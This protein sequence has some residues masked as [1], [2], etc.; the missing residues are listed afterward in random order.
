MITLEIWQVNE[1]KT[2]YLLLTLILLGIP[3]TGISQ[4]TDPDYLYLAED[5]ITLHAG[6]S[7]GKQIQLNDTYLSYYYDTVVYIVSYLG[8]LTINLAHFPSGTYEGMEQ[9]LTRYQRNVTL[10][11]EKYPAAYRRAENTTVPE[12]E[13]IYVSMHSF[14]PTEFAG[15]S[16]EDREAAWKTFSFNITVTGVG[17]VTLY[18]QTIGT[19]KPT[20]DVINAPLPVMP[21]LVALLVVASSTRYLHKRQRMGV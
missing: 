21:I 9:E 14:G 19:H 4:T 8:N 2:V 15:K 3:L 17:N 12:E 18:Y 11:P 20:T 7:Y 1:M 5:K 16:F 13:A 6:D 10:N